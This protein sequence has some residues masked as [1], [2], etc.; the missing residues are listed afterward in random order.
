VPL[1]VRSNPATH[2]NVVVL[3]HPE[4]PSSV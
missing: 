3:P 4:G 1:S 2:L